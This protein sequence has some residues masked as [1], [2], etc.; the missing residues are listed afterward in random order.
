MQNFYYKLVKDTVVDRAL[1][2]ARIP[3]KLGQAKFLLK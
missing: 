1:R 3:A 2:L